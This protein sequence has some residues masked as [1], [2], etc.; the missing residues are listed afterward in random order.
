MVQPKQR[1]IPSGGVVYAVLPPHTPAVFQSTTYAGTIGV[2]FSGHKGA[3]RQYRSGPIIE[4]D[5]VPGAASV[6][7]A[8]DLD[9]LRVREPSECWEFRPSHRLVAS[10]ANELGAGGTLL[11]PEVGGVRDAVIW[12]AAFASRAALLGGATTTRLEES[13]RIRLLVRHILVTYGGIRPR[14]RAGQSRLSPQRLA[15]VLEYMESGSSRA[16]T[17]ERLA[18]VAALSPFH[19][20]RMFRQT[21]GV[22]PHAFVVAR[23][24]QRARDL[25]VTHGGPVAMIARAAEYANPAHF[26]RA[27]RRAFG[28]SPREFAVRHER[29]R[30]GWLQSEVRSER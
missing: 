3:V 17:L 28:V 5:I 11:L 15:R 16:M 30:A 24:L 25:L 8:G 29:L 2:S 6:T 9:W 27:F 12:S 19:F 1:R 20:L 21:T 10:I 7:T 18:D 14:N 23:R 26:R 4:K 13:T 22:T